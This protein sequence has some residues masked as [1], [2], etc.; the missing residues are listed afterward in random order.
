MEPSIPTS[1]N[2]P[3]EAENPTKEPINPEIEQKESINSEKMLTPEEEGLVY[4]GVE[5]LFP[6]GLNKPLSVLNIYCYLKKQKPN[7]RVTA[8]EIEDF[9]KETWNLEELTFHDENNNLLLF[10]SDYIE[11]AEKSEHKAER[12]SFTLNFNEKKGE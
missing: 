5:R 7:S 1:D 3:S 10:E 8:Q 11:F 6:V 2:N 4:E 9:L 12:I